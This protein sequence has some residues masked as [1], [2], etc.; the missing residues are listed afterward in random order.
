[1]VE[2]QVYSVGPE[3][4]N[5]YI[6]QY[7]TNQDE[8]AKVPPDAERIESAKSRTIPKTEFHIW[9]YQNGQWMKAEHKNIYI[10]R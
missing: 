9:H 3:F 7:E 1:V 2:I 10:K 6:Q 8:A 4:V 5:R